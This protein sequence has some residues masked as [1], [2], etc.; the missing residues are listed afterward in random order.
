[1]KEGDIGA[2]LYIDKKEEK[3]NELPIDWDAI[4]ILQCTLSSVLSLFAAF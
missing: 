1:V 2:T 4:Y 3:K